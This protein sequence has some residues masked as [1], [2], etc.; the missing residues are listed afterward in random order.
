MNDSTH[1]LIFVYT[2]SKYRFCVYNKSSQTGNIKGSVI[3]MIVSGNSHLS[4]NLLA[5]RFPA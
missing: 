1:F 2:N 5:L 4:K 3:R